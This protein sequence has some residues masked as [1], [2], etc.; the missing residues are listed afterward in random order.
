MAMG[1]SAGEIYSYA[2]KDFKADQQRRSANLSDGLDNRLVAGMDQDGD[3]VISTQEIY[4]FAA[5]DF[6]KGK[7]AAAKSSQSRVTG[8]QRKVAKDLDGD[9]VIS[10][11]EAI[12]ADR[13][14]MDGDGELNEAEERARHRAMQRAERE[15]AAIDTD[16]DGIISREE[17]VAVAV[18]WKPPPVKQ[19]TFKTWHFRADEQPRHVSAVQAAAQQCL[20]DRKMRDKA[21][22]KE[23]NAREAFDKYDANHS[24]FLVEK[25]LRAALH[26]L[27]ITFTEEELD[28]V[29]EM[30]DKDQSL[31]LDFS[32]F[33]KLANQLR[34]AGA[35]RSA[36]GAILSDAAQ[37][38]H[39]E[40][41]RREAALTNMWQK[42]SEQKHVSI[43]A[44]A[45]LFR[46]HSLF[47][48]FSVKDMQQLFR[49]ANRGY[50][51]DHK[52]MMLDR[53][54]FDKALT[55]SVQAARER[56][57]IRGNPRRVLM[58]VARLAWMCKELWPISVSKPKQHT[59]HQPP[60]EQALGWR[61]RDPWAALSHD[62]Q[63]DEPKF[64]EYD[65]RSAAQ[66]RRLPVTPVPKQQNLDEVDLFGAIKANDVVLVRQVLQ[67]CP[68]R[69]CERTGYQHTLLHQAIKASMMDSHLEMVKILVAAGV[70]T[71]AVDCYQR[72]ALH[73][74]GYLHWRHG[75][76]EN[77]EIA[78]VLLAAKANPDLGDHQS[79][80]PLRAAKVWN[81]PQ[82]AV[83]LRS[84]L[85]PTPKKADRRGQD[86]FSYDEFVTRNGLKYKNNSG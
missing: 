12:S 46:D 17:A 49:E 54:E 83:V 28:A 6:K 39:Q 59:K 53:S 38:D 40:N 36:R 80:T 47:E 73:H 79:V 1:I 42:Y 35:N 8:M 78:Q 51:S 7:G 55:M 61:Q 76:G 3:G 33:E 56:C 71:N 81:N 77:P 15:M 84:G 34:C 45:K 67:Q 32:E 30:Y 50:G 24:G 9:G 58:D 27:Q 4:S 20:L 48:V 11:E 52:P 85:K 10:R 18:D 29:L 66:N 65:R 43:D 16:G 70:D 64:R 19:C 82:T 26:G 5:R 23:L 31:M 75:E 63:Q 57:A 41:V 2:A 37:S 72:S 22:E 14:D 21:E 68:A 62:L 86:Q 69:W 44:F 60:D 13:F 74:T 25:E